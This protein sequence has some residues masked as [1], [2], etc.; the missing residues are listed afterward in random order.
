MFPNRPLGPSKRSRIMESCPPRILLGIANRKFQ[1]QTILTHRG[2]NNHWVFPTI[3]MRILQSTAVQRYRNLD[4]LRV[5][6][7]I[8]RQILKGNAARRTSQWR[9][10]SS[11]TRRKLHKTAGRLQLRFRIH[12]SSTAEEIPKTYLWQYV[13]FGCFAKL[14]NE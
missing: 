6:L 10:Q 5:L 1:G 14:E 12:K 11:T 7:G 2:R 13:F 8:A 4:N 3:F 9:G